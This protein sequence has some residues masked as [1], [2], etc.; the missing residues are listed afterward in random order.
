MRLGGLIILAAVAQGAVFG[1]TKY[2]NNFEKAQVG[3]VPE[4]FLVLDGAFAVKE[5]EGNKV[6]ELPGAPLDTF[7]V[8]FGPTEKEN[9]AVTARVLGQ[10]KG[11]RYPVFDVGLD[12]VGGYKL[13]V[14]PGKK[15][16][17]LYKGDAVKNSVPLEWKPGKW[18]HLKL[19]VAK[20]ADKEW[21]IQG[22]VWEDGA[23]PAQPTIEWTE[24]EEPAAGR[25]SVS[26]M[27][28]SGLPI[29]FDDLV[30]SA[31]GTK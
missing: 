1:Q 7:G 29:D 3:A 9:V 18:T 30:V 12:G 25:A 16:L 6:L 14:S 11:R 13:R 17:E 28:Y 21:K 31:V 15:Q 27:P 8:L 23:E 5:I 26:G 24:T 4:D 10:A 2:E 20:S 22:K 19:Q